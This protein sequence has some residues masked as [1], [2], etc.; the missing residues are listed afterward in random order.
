MKKILVVSIPILF[1]FYMPQ[2]VFSQSLNWNIQFLSGT[3]QNS[4]PIDEPIKMENGDELSLIVKAG[5]DCYL[6]AFWYNSERRISVFHNQALKKGTIENFDGPFYITKPSGTETVYVIMSRSR[7]ANLEKLIENC[8][9]N[10]GSRLHENN[11]Y[12][13]IIN[14]QNSVSTVEG[15]YGTPTITSASTERGSLVTSFT[16]QETY[17][18]AISIEH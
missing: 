2:P 17:V 18:T 11:L 8:E 5:A 9:K 16:G 1:L 15:H 13:E 14:L 10:K 7:Q 3:A 12:N 6:Y 4:R